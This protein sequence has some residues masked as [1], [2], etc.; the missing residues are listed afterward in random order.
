MILKR[1]SLLQ[2]FSLLS[3]IALVVANFA[4]G[5]LITHNL[6]QHAVEGAKELTARI[7]LSEV[8]NEF[9]RE[10]L[11]SAKVSDY[12]KF[13]KKIKHL[14]FG[15]NVVRLK[16]WSKDRVVIWSDD[17]RL[18]GQ[19]FHDNHELEEAFDGEIPSEI[20]MLE[21]AE[22][23][24]DRPYKKLLELYVPIRFDPGGEIE[25]V[26][27]IYQNLDP[28][29]EDISR[30]KK[31][32]WLVTTGGF[33]MLYLLLFGIV[34]GAS[35]KID[36]QF[37]QI[38]ESEKKLKDYSEG[39]EVKVRERTQELEE[40]KIMAE[41][42]SKAKS[43][44]LANMS[45]ELRTP[46]NSIIGFSQAVGQ[47]LAGPVSDE[48]KGY[49][50]DILESGRHLLDIINEI[51]DLAKIEAGKIVLDKR[52]IAIEE[53]IRTSILLFREKALKH[54]IRLETDIAPDTGT[55][56]GDYKRLKQVIINFLGNAFKFTPDG[57]SITLAARRES[58]GDG[59]ESIMISVSDTGIGIRPED[60]QRL[61]R[62]F[63]QL[64]P[65]LTKSHEGT[66]LGLAL[67]K[68][69]VELHGG[70]IWAE[71]AEGTGSTFFFTIP[72]GHREEPGE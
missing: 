70:R 27:E 44:F 68:D 28:L 9:S 52:D 4:L 10:D 29:E 66:G 15:P 13:T 56:Q 51:L 21:K 2:R 41:S 32:I 16:I 50:N 12:E 19:R 42:A 18:V 8:L 34:R 17:Q 36:Q 7:V 24:F 11:A 23:S 33:L 49:L 14:T 20:S 63:E 25:N 59:T 22:Q 37:F 39:L 38:R 45:H 47:G 69:I 3:L 55:V 58:G 72:A 62:P 31:L 35:R 46:L 43:D 65:S 57:G 48:Q 64:E 26:F 71:S 30:Q 40:A 67:S 5:T 60:Q 1:I 61:F 53:L 6:H 54:S